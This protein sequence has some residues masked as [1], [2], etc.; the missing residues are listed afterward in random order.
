MWSKEEILNN[1][2]DGWY[3]YWV[4]TVMVRESGI[5]GSVVLIFDCI[6]VGGSEQVFTL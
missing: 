6:I 1:A 3:L 2:Q 4:D 5:M